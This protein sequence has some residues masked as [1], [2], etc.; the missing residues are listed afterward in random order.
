[1]IMFKISRRRALASLGS[2]ALLPL[3]P[4]TAFAKT[5]SDPFLHGIASGDPDATSVVLWTHVTT[6]ERTAKVTWAIATDSAFK[7]VI[8]TGDQETNQSRDYTVKV[9]AK[10]LAP[11]SVYFYRFEYQNSFSEIGRTKTLAN[12]HLEKLGIAVTSCSNYPFGYFN[13]YDAIAKDNDIDFVLHLG[14]YIYEYGANGWG[15]DVGKNIDRVHFPANEIVTLTDYRQRHAQYKSDHGSKRMLATHPLIA[16]WDDHE[17]ANNPWTGGA[18]NHQPNTEGDW[19]KRRQA[20]TQAYYEW[21]PVREPSLG[22][23]PLEYWRNFRFGDLASMTTL[24][25]RHT[26]RAEQIDYAIHLP[27]LKTQ[28]DRNSFVKTVLGDP[29][30]NMLSKKMEAYLSE[31]LTKAQNNQRWKLIANQIPIARTHIPVLNDP[32]FKALIETPNNP[33]AKEWAAAARLGELD[34]PFYMDTWDGYPVARQRFYE[35]CQAAGTSDL[36]VLTGDSHAFWQ[37]QLFDDS[38]KAMG[39]ELGTTGISSPGDFLRLGKT[40][41][42]LLDNLVAEKNKEVVW[43]DNSHNG[44]IRLLLTHANATADYVAVS[45]VLEPNYSIKLVKSVDIIKQDNSLIYRT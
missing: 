41:S 39:V 37:N 29:S 31:S 10:D 34:L 27:K 4:K 18:E 7:Q 43:T 21:M 24:E 32:V 23:N 9:L 22:M 1:M 36:V 16:I 3:L 45:T 17:S 28:D 6:S 42:D 30:R 26:G 38:G 11:N 33:L 15:S 19:Q 12:G 13:A 5:S 35:L 2:I 20:S 25:T 8:L 40:G 44:Y 14:D